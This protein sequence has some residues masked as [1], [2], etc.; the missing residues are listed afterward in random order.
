MQELIV[1]HTDELAQS[2]TR[3]QGKTIPDAKGDVFRGLEVVEQACGIGAYQMGC[4][5]TES[6]FKHR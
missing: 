1:S 6:S 5:Q 3:E 2:I 4:V